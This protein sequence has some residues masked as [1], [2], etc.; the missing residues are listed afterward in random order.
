[1][2]VHSQAAPTDPNL[3][4]P[5]WYVHD[6]LGSV[7]QVVKLNESDRAT[8]KNRYAYTP[9]GEDLAAV[10]VET[11]AN[12]FQFTG[13][14]YDAEIG[15]YHLRAR[16]YDPAMMR[17]TARDPVRGEQNEPLTSH[18]YLYCLNDS[19]NK[20]DLGGEFANQIAGSVLAGAAV[21]AEGINTAAYGAS[22]GNWK[23]FELSFDI[24][25]YGVP[26]AMY[27]G[28]VGFLP[29]SAANFCFGLFWT[30]TVGRVV[31]YHMNPISSTVM[32]WQSTI[33]FYGLVT[34]SANRHGLTKDEIDDFNS[35]MYPDWVNEILY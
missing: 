31:D 15:Q 32:P 7:R 17:F 21:Y 13:Q 16:M 6:R 34:W 11:V 29:D 2:R 19:V 5:R 26:G 27:L 24:L 25:Q 35:W 8:V 22:T 28:A 18:R 12:P 33:Y 1:M 9:F 20:M 10:T 23:F 30:G 4:E 14:W 3:Y